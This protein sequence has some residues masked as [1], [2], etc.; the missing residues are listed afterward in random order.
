M[1]GS[2]DGT[3]SK[4]TWMYKGLAGHV[5]S[6]EY[7]LGRKIDKTFMLIKKEEAGIKSDFD[8]EINS[9]PQSVLSASSSRPLVADAV[10]KL[11][12]DPLFE[13]KKKEMEKRKEILLNPVKMKRLKTLLQSAL[14]SDDSS[15]SDSSSD[16]DSNHKRKKRRHGKKDRKSSRGRSPSG[17]ERESVNRRDKSNRDHHSDHPSHRH[18]EDRHENKHKEK[19]SS[20]RDEKS[21]ND[22]KSRRQESSHR[23]DHHDTNRHS[24][25]DRRKESNSRSCDNHERLRSKSAE[26][27]KLDEGPKERPRDIKAQTK[28]FYAKPAARPKLSA[29]ELERRRK[30]MMQDATER[31]KERADRVKKFKEQE[32]REKASENKSG[33]GFLKPILTQKLEESS[34]ESRVKQ[35][36][37][38]SQRKSS[39]MDQNF[40]RK[41]LH[42]RIWRCFSFMNCSQVLGNLL[43]AEQQNNNNHDKHGWLLI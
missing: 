6:E 3:E 8:V 24:R 19:P 37:F 18:N 43:E 20:H 29:A 23:K 5:D 42:A 7:L 35:K 38:S 41:W 30:E 21:R 1:S 26:K 34:V 2:T 27:S 14:S 40:A 13:I 39:S 33:A 4:M 31:D 22:G 16:D 9:V 32:E 12:E 17:K 25:D 10:A 36:L 11:R 15:S 28:P